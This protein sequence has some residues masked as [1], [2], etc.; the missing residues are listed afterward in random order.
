MVHIVGDFMAVGVIGFDTVSFY[1]AAS[2]SIQAGGDSSRRSF[3]DVKRNIV[4][5][6][7][8]AKPTSLKIHDNLV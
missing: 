8:T 7:E 5:T 3:G 6:G 1:L 2:A 4:F